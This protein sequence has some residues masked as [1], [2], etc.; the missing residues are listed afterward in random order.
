MEPPRT[1]PTALI[2]V[3]RGWQWAM[4]TA[5]GTVILQSLSRSKVDAIELLCSAYG[6]IIRGS[7][8]DMK[9]PADPATQW[10]WACLIRGLKWH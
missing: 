6:G 7:L 2:P 8:V 4:V 10:C 1:T 3:K 5:V 9:L